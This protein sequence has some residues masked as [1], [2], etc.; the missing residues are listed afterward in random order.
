MTSAA[1]TAAVSGSLLSSF[2]VPI[3]K[4]IDK[5]A[6]LK[7]VKRLNCHAEHVGSEAIKGVLVEVVFFL[8]LLDQLA[9][10]RHDVVY[11]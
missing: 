4:L 2:P 10:A 5:A 7:F 8:D 1:V 11:S 3:K 6:R 9:V